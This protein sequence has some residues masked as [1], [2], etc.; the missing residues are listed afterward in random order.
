M[1]GCEDGTLTAPLPAETAAGSYKHADAAWRARHS[2]SQRPA[3]C[4]QSGGGTCGFGPGFLQVV[5]G[6][7]VDVR[8]GRRAGPG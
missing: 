6:I 2:G 5:G 8:G 1:E 4:C 3:A 7:G